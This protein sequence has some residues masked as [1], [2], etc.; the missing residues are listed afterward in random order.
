MQ[1]TRHLVASAAELAAGVQL[2]EH[3]L[4]GGNALF[5]VNVDRY[6]APVVGDGNRAFT[7]Y[8]DRDGVAVACQRLVDG[9][10]DYLDDKVV[11]SPLVGRADVH[12]GALSDRLKSLK[13]LNLAGVVIVIDFIGHSY[14]PFAELHAWFYMIIPPFREK[15]K[16][17][18]AISSP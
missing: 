8:L 14:L 10:V 13:Y 2:G 1:A 3:Y 16:R 9:I 12:A 4:N 17:F 11:K 7:G 6:A 18:S 15:E 5:R